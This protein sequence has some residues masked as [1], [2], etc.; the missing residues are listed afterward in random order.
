VIGLDVYS[1]VSPTRY[2]CVRNAGPG[3]VIVLAGD[4]GG[5]DML[6]AG[7]VIAGVVAADMVTAAFVTA[8]FVTAAF[9]TEALVGRLFGVRDCPVLADAILFAASD[10]PEIRRVAGLRAT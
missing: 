2:L 1:T 6:T 8:A 4:I 9:V 10:L 5:G 3:I 7:A